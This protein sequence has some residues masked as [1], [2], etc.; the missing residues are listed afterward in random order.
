MKNK[1]HIRE[2]NCPKRTENATRE[3]ERK[4]CNKQ[5]FSAIVMKLFILSLPDFRTT[6]QLKDP[7]ETPQQYRFIKTV[8][9]HVF[10]PAQ[11]G[12]KLAYIVSGKKFVLLRQSMASPK[13]IQSTRGS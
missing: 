12:L 7:Y 13:N 11:E 10:K 3:I 5:N 4:H 8:T 9:A 6:K 1:Q 2:K